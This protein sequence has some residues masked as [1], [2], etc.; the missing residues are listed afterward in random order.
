MV[1]PQLDLIALNGFSEVL[2]SGIPV[3]ERVQVLEAAHS[4]LKDLL[5]LV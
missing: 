5:G 1:L 3:F 2:G 4:Y